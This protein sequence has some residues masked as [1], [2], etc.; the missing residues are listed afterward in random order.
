MP[1]DGVS[2]VRDQLPPW[3]SL[4]WSSSSSS[5]AIEDEGG[6]RWRCVVGISGD[7]SWIRGGVKRA[8]RVSW[9]AASLSLSFSS[10]SS[11]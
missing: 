5:F 9:T 2:F 8:R 6:G 7:P 10:S 11:Y 4:S 1:A 3:L